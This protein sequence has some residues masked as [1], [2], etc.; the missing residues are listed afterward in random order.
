MIPHAGTM[1]L[2]DEVQRWNDAAIRCISRS[3]RDADNPMRAG[4]ELPAL[5]GI[6]YA[7][8]A[9]AVHGRLSAAV[10]ERPRA[11]FI[12]SVSDVV[13]RARRL[14]DLEHDL[15]IEVE[16]LAADG[17]RVLYRFALSAG[18]REILH[19]KAAVV[20]DAHPTDRRNAQ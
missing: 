1:C 7:A 3:H 14:D 2:L 17:P 20:L 10:T 12:V 6:E 4:S 13:C 15:V 11:G 9:M 16:R 8:Q 19:G 18:E 5:C